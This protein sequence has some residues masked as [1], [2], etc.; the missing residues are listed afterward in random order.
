M[1]FHHPL[2][3]ICTKEVIPCS[4]IADI[5]GNR[6][7]ERYAVNRR[8]GMPGPGNVPVVEGHKMDESWGQSLKR[9]RRRRYHDPNFA[10]RE[11]G[12]FS[13]DR[14]NHAV[15]YLRAG[16]LRSGAATGSLV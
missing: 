7:L 8:N 3:R 6:R 15:V 10:R 11:S 2:S 4:G 13:G 12:I 16:R 14:A 9:A 1:E 5:E